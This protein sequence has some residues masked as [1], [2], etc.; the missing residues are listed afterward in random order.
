MVIKKP[1]IKEKL[2][3]LRETISYFKTCLKLREVCDNKYKHEIHS[4]YLVKYVIY[5]YNYVITS[6]F[7]DVLN[8]G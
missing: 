6:F 1:L 7:I 4:F 2:Y 8:Y 5:I 3:I